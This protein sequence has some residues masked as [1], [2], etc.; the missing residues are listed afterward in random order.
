MRQADAVALARDGREIADAGERSPA[1]GPEAQEREDVALPVVRIEPAEP[2][3][4]EIHLVQRGLGTVDRVQVAYEPLNARVLGTLEQLP[5]ERDVV[6]PLRL[7]GELTAHE[8][9]LSVNA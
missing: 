4:L 9:Q 6:I 8:Q 2:R 3:R 7:L 5:V 1:F